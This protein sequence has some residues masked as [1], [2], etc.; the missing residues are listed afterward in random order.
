MGQQA[1]LEVQRRAA[2]EQRVGIRATAK[3][4]FATAGL[5]HI[6]VQGG[7]TH[8]RVEEGFERLSDHRLQRESLDRRTNPGLLHHLR[9]HA[10]HRLHG[11]AAL[12]GAA[13]GLHRSEGAVLDHQFLHFGQLMNFHSALGRLLGVA[14]GNRVMPGGATVDVP[15]AGEYR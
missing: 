9:T 13:I 1:F 3:H 2:V 14:P 5:L 12:D 7:R 10:R 8:Q 4:H 15:Q 11:A 6:A